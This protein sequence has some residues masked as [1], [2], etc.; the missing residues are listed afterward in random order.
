MNG[1]YLDT[2]EIARMLKCNSRTVINMI[3]TGL[4]NGICLG[5][6][7]SG[8]GRKEYR[9]LKSEYENYINKAKV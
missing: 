5:S 2:K 1:D 4:L 9:V 3:K 8:K 6:K 7:K